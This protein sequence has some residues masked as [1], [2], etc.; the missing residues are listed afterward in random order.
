V[1][2]KAKTSVPRPYGDLPEGEKEYTAKRRSKPLKV[3]VA[4]GYKL[5]R[6]PKSK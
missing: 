6:S 3:V 5:R 1:I 4:L 2:T